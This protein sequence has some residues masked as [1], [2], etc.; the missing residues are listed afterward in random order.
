MTDKNVKRA[1]RMRRVRARMRA[2]AV[3]PRL[4]VFRSNRHI[5]AQLIDDEH[6]VTLASASDAETGLKSKRGKAP[7]LSAAAGEV[8]RLIAEKAEKKGIKKAAF[9]RGGYKYHGLVA[10]LAE[11]ARKGGLEF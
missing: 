7:G 5:S 10:A 4:S 3:I 1:R 6:G 9:D 8:G 11:G 2:A